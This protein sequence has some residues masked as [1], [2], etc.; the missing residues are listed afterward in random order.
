MNVAELILEIQNAGVKLKF[1]PS[2]EMRAEGSA[3]VIQKWLPDI[4]ARKA[5]IVTCLQS[6][7]DPAM[8]FWR[9]RIHFS[10]RGP[11]EVTFS[12]EATLAEVVEQYPDATAAEPV[13]PQSCVSR[14]HSLSS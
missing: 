7:I 12:P 2:G 8:A 6:G 10:D 5:E 3:A 13:Q 4:R 11:L 14:V 9:W 1:S